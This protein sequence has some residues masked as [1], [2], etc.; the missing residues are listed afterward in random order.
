MQIANISIIAGSSVGQYWSGRPHRLI[1][2]N[3]ISKLLSKTN[4][5]NR[6]VKYANGKELR[7]LSCGVQKDLQTEIVVMEVTTRRMTHE[8]WCEEYWGAFRKP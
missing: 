3:K 4:T 6:E 1:E 2:V 8:E 7:A 5:W